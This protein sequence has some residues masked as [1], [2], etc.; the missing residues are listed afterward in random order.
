MGAGPVLVVTL[1]AALVVAGLAVRPVPEPEATTL[2]H[3]VIAG[4]PGLTWR[5]VD[6]D[7]TPH[8]WRLAGSGA[9]GS[10]TPRSARHP[11]C[12]TDGWLTLGA[13]NFAADTL[14]PTR[15]PCPPPSLTVEGSGATGAYLPELET[16]VRDNRW[17]M[18]WE[19]VPGALAGAVECTTAI[20]P[21][22]PVAAARVY[23]RVDRYVP[24]LPTD[25]AQLSVLLDRCELAVVDLGEVSGEGPGRARAVRAVDDAVGRLVESRPAGALLLVAGVADTDDERRLRL[26]IAE[27]PGFTGGWLTSRSTGRPGHLQLVDLAPTAVTALGRP[28]PQVRLAGHPAEVVPGRSGSLAEDVMTLVRA[29]TGAE[30]AGPARQAFLL[31]WV[32]GFLLLLLVSVPVLRRVRAGRWRDRLGPLPV[33]VT[34]IGPAALVAGGLPWWRTEPAEAVFVASLL[35]LVAAGTALVVA[36]WWP[37][38]MLAVM[39][40]TAGLTALV[41]AADLAT[42]SRLQLD[43]ILGYSARDGE[44]FTGLGP[45][46]AGLLVAGVLLAAGALTQRVAWRWRPVV[47]VALGAA[48]VL[49]VGSPFLGADTGMAVSLTAGVCL[50]AVVSAGGWFTVS[51]LAW[52]VLAGVA[53]TLGL[54]AIELRRPVEQR[55]GLGRLVTELGEG[56]LGFS[57]QRVSLANWEALAGSPLNLVAVAAAVFA[58]LVLMR[59]FGG[60][61]RVFGIYPALRAGM[62][63]TVAASLIGGVVTGSALIVAGAA[64]TVAVPLALFAAARTRTVTV[65]TVEPRRPVAAGAPVGGADGSGAARVL[66]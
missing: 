17:Q 65:P 59:P 18:P 63:G 4:A 15:G 50:A 51:R 58:W 46:A 20:G 3:V 29:D 62:A 10:L 33:A 56:T 8:L 7:R 28:L 43:G 23:G 57:L 34:L 13:G 54:V 48:G 47:V 16:L 53:V 26:V 41:V 49:V 31:W 55:S 25:P 22:A 27:G 19:A 37:R 36:L 38:G 30:R 45:V 64:A 5:D 1:L 42:G 6:P 39:A 12:L 21:H 9:V 14:G 35:A 52:A 2:T 11:T 66:G 44:R 61:R 32:V 24:T 60:L 40:G